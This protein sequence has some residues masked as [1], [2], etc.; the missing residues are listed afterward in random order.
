[1]IPTPSSDESTPIEIET[2]E[3]E[4]S[5]TDL[6]LAAWNGEYEQVETILA[7]VNVNQPEVLSFDDWEAIGTALFYS[8]QEGH[9][10]I[11]QLLID[12][13]AS[14][15]IDAMLIYKD[16]DKE[17]YGPLLAAAARGHSEI[18]RILLEAGA[19]PNPFAH[20][21]APDGKRV[22]YP[23]LYTAASE[24]HIDVVKLLLDFGADM[25]LNYISKQLDG[26]KESF[27]PL[28]VAEEQIREVLE[29]YEPPEE[30]VEMED[31]DEE[32][33]E[34]EDEDQVEEA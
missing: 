14:T 29:N 26:T 18:V 21:L 16:G 34:A 20:T 22:A 25:T 23:A 33:E 17:I 10:E 11:V 31:E 4:Y 7:S 13:N 30:E 15:H 1:M 5:A 9:A 19:D 2:P 28:D 3:V 27:S 12:N 8:A 6:V 24:N 32:I